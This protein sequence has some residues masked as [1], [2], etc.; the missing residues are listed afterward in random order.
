MELLFP[1]AEQHLT[2]FISCLSD[3]GLKE[4]NQHNTN[5]WF[6]LKSFRTCAE[7]VVLLKQTTNLE[8]KD[9]EKTLI[10]QNGDYFA[11]LNVLF[12][13]EKNG[14]VQV[15]DLEEAEKHAKSIDTLRSFLEKLHKEGYVTPMPAHNLPCIQLREMSKVKNELYDT[16]KIVN[17]N[18]WLEKT[19]PI[20]SILGDEV[21]I[22]DASARARANT[23]KGII[24]V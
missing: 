22:I 15:T 20:A 17:K 10:R 7:V 14:R 2:S 16:I 19:A 6:K 9:V 18:F 13:L 21:V 1:T 5:G 12:K 8:W 23:E 3:Y 24:E 11:K 4:T